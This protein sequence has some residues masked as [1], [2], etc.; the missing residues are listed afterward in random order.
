MDE[1][2]TKPIDRDRLRVTLEHFAALIPV[3]AEGGD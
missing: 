1:Y 2:L 3:E